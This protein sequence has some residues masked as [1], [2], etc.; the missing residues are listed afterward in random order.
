MGAAHRENESIDDLPVIHSLSD[1]YEFH[2][3]LISNICFDIFL[4]HTS[5]IAQKKNEIIYIYV[6]YYSAMFVIYVCGKKRMYV[7]ECLES[8][9][10]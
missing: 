1:R 5:S 10:F 8:L 6:L 3:M 9:D 7:K 2:N 4:P